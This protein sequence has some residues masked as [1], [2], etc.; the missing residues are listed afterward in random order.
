M[1]FEATAKIT[2]EKW[3]YLTLPLEH[4]LQSD[5]VVRQLADGREEAMLSPRR[6]GESHASFVLRLPPAPDVP[7]RGR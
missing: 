1:C 3:L 5:G 6:R 7:G 2:C 4:N